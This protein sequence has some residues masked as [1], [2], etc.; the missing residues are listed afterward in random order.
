VHTERRDRDREP[1]HV[2]IAATQP[3]LANQQPQQRLVLRPD[4]IETHVAQ[5]QA[6][7]RAVRT[8]SPIAYIL[9]TSGSTGDPKGVVLT[10]ENV[11]SQIR[12]IDGMLHLSAADVALGVLPFFH[13]YGYTTTLWTPLA[14][15]PAVVYHTDPRDAQTVGRDVEAQ[16]D[17]LAGRQH[18]GGVEGEVL[19]LGLAVQAQA[20]GQG[21]LRQTHLL[22]GQHHSP[23]LSRTGQRRIHG[24]ADRQTS[25]RGQAQGRGLH[26]PQALGQVDRAT[27]GHFQRS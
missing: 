9:F 18:Q 1:L 10:I 26:I 11:G 12:A 2:G 20:G 14:L 3:E 21:G 22:G 13:S 4:A 25:G 23:Y 16:V 5:A 27:R 8:G 19:D 15:D 17:G 7:A 6:P 24:R